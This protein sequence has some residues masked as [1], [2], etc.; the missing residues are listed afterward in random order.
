MDAWRA[1]L[2]D[3]VE[4]TRAEDGTELV[5][6]LLVGVVGERRQQVFGDLNTGEVLDAAQTGRVGGRQQAGPDR[7]GDAGAAGAFDEGA[8]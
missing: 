3:R 4:E 8:A 5:A 2:Q 7:D 6:R 1:R